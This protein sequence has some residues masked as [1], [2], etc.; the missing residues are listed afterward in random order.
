MV[1]CKTAT[2]TPN[3][4]PRFGEGHQSKYICISEW[5]LPKTWGGQGEGR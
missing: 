1:E 5:L 4:S 2:L 3:P